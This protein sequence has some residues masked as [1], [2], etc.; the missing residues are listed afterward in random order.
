MNKRHDVEKAGRKGREHKKSVRLLCALGE[1]GTRARVR[2]TGPKRGRMMGSPRD[3]QPWMDVP[4]MLWD[5]AKEYWDSG[6]DEDILILMDNMDGLDWVWRHRKILRDRDT[7]EK[8]LLHA[9]SAC[10]VNWCHIPLLNLRYLF[11]LADQHKMILAADPLPDQETF[12]LYRGV[13][14]RGKYRRV[15]GISWTS[16]I[17]TAEFFAARFK[18]RGDPAVYRIKVSR[19]SIFARLHESYRNE[20]EYLVPSDDIRPKRLKEDSE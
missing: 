20:N 6:R 18:D 16:D 1:L 17:T 3:Q 5:L 13:A 8:S 15:S 19:D 12:T 4:A 11:S 14:G 2:P 9:Y 7:Y 10:R